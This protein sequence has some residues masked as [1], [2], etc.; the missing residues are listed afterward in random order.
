MSRQNPE[1]EEGGSAPPYSWYDNSMRAPP[2][3]Y[4]ESQRNG[5][6]FNHQQAPAP[7]PAATAN[8]PNQYYGMIYHNPQVPVHVQMQGGYN[9]PTVM[10]HGV[11][12][13][14]AGPST[15]AGAAASRVLQLDPRAEI[16]TTST[17]AVSVPPPPPGCLPT[18]AQ[19]AAMQGQPVTVKQN[20]RSFF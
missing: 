2:P 1:K 15:S 5:G 6:A 3:T 10:H 20:K 11:G 7:H 19:L 4:E 18:P 17:G 9:S 13:G 8:N 12:Y 14:L 16:R